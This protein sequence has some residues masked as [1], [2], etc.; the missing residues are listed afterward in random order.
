M[1]APGQQQ[2]RQRRL[3]PA[4]VTHPMR[5]T[6]PLLA[7]YAAVVGLFGDWLLGRHLAPASG[8]RSLVPRCVNGHG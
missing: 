1:R 7:Y 8:R 6:L 3:C 2:Q 5:A 4:A